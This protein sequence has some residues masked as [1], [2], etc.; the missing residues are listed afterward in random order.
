[1]RK[2]LYLQIVLVDQSF[3]T[4]SF[5][6]AIASPTCHGLPREPPGITLR[7]KGEPRKRGGG[8]REGVVSRRGA[9]GGRTDKRQRWSGGHNTRRPGREKEAGES[10][11]GEKV[12][13]TFTEQ[14]PFRSKVM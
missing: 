4:F 13:K 14:T 8:R 12:E 6:R 7:L 5:V 3:K 10:E 2:R 11:G 1:M 9:R